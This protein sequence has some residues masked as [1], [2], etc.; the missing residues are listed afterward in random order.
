MENPLLR[1]APADQM[2]ALTADLLAA[3]ETPSESMPT[4]ACLSHTTLL[5]RISELRQGRERAV[6]TR[7][8]EALLQWL[9]ASHVLKRLPLEQPAPPAFRLYALG[10]PASLDLEPTELLMA[11]EPQ[12]VVCYFTALA[13][14]GLTTQQPVHH[15]VARIRAEAIRRATPYA[16]TNPATMREPPLGTRR[17]FW[18]G[19]PYFAT[20]RAGYTLKGLVTQVLSPRSWVRITS[21]EQSLL[22]TFHRPVHCGG[23][24]VV[25]EAWETA[26]P[27]L[28]EARLH[29]LLVAL[30]DDA[31][32]RR[33]GCLFDLLTYRP[34][35][36]LGS[37]LAARRT[38]T[39]AAPLALF[40]HLPMPGYDA[41]W[42]VLTPFA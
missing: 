40:P 25:W 1:A 16:V 9:A 8:R 38:V 2:A 12:G 37:A 35:T 19:I 20:D 17:F 34:V 15:H 27:N 21:R 4:V 29:D 32:W 26:L 14:H 30:D 18:H 31:L 11:T 28:D 42:R 23:L 41:S 24:A 13:A 5:R 7:P 6:A 22:D 36:A 10:A 3:F 39:D 33:V